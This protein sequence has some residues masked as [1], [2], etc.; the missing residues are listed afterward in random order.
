[1]AKKGHDDYAVGYGRPRSIHASRRAS[2]AIRR[3]VKRV[4]KIFLP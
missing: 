3:V 1:M 2:L 4:A